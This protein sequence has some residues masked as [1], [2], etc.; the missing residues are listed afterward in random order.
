V[1]S[2]VL[3]GPRALQSVPCLG[4]DIYV[5]SGDSKVVVARKGSPL[6]L[7]TTTDIE[8][9]R[10]DS[11]V[12]SLKVVLY[13]SSSSPDQSAGVQI[14]QIVFQVPEGASIGEMMLTINVIMSQT[15]SLDVCVQHQK[16]EL[17]RFSVHGP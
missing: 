7:S 10:F 11:D 9:P 1:D 8:C 15:G 17:G 3:E 4:E 5:V 16:K 12:S 13:M 6:P 2:G 14:G